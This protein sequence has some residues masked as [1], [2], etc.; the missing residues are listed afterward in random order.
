MQYP[1]LERAIKSIL[2]QALYEK[3]QSV[4]KE[5]ESLLRLLRV[6]QQHWYNGQKIRWISAD[7]EGNAFEKRKIRND[8]EAVFSISGDRRRYDILRD[9]WE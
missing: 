1:R 6:R 2:A 3:N 7:K 5:A 9:K 4:Y 8:C